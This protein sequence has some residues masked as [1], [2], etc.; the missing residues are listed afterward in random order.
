LFDFYGFWR[1]SGFN[2]NP[3]KANPFKKHE[4]GSHTIPQWNLEDQVSL[5]LFQVTGLADFPG[6]EKITEGFI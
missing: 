6:V 3:K 5:E 1:S 2:R 4:S